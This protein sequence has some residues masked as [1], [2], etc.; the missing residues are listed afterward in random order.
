MPSTPETP[1]P[2]GPGSAPDPGSLAAYAESAIAEDDALV[3][4]RERA[5]EIGARA[6]SP[7][8]GA[9]LCLLARLADARAVVEIGTGAGV[10]GLWLL[11][12]MRS[13]GVLTTIDPDADHHRA[14]RAAFTAAGIAGSRTR[15]I[16]GRAGEV[17]PRLADASYDIVFVDGPVIDQPRY[18]SEALRLLR[19]GG[20]LLVHDVTA[21]GRIADPAQTDPETAAARQA[22][23]IVSEDD[24]LIPVVIPL[25]R[26][27]LAAVRTPGAAAGL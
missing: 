1:S 9:A 8:V 17:L 7:A 22:A 10:S 12:G 24:G 21:D 3:A 18:I 14:A 26:G 23:L 5:V 4:A 11:G 16:T 2:A 15:L 27:L 20:L 19:G 6:V 13:D 25:G